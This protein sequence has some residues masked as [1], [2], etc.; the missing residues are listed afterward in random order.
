MHAASLALSEQPRLSLA[1]APRSCRSTLILEGDRVSRQDRPLG[2]C[3]HG[4]YSNLVRGQPLGGLLIDR[5]CLSS[6]LMCCTISRCYQNARDILFMAPTPAC[7]ALHS[8]NL[9]NVAL[10]AYGQK[11]KAAMPCTS[12]ISPRPQSLARPCSHF[13][14]FDLAPLCCG[15]RW[16]PTSH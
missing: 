5:Q 8:S 14:C 12:N 6:R 16:F 9:A 2:H 11:M 10:T 15:A 13:F 1:P 7:R 4:F 3:L